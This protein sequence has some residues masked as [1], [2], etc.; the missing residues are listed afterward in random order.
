MNLKR[1]PSLS[2]NETM[3]KRRRTAGAENCKKGGNVY[4]VISLSLFH[5]RASVRKKEKGFR[6]GGEKRESDTSTLPTQSKLNYSSF[7]IR[8]RERSSWKNCLQSKDHAHLARNGNCGNK[9]AQKCSVE[10]KHES[11]FVFQS[12]HPLSYF[13]PGLVWIDEHSAAKLRIPAE[14]FANKAAER[15]PEI[16]YRLRGGG[17][18][19]PQGFLI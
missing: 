12:R 2:T 10:G 1:V 14:S 11:G 8:D 9:K 4:V 3:S 5:C 19:R 15:V 13:P 7:H 6:R 16:G 18:G 17:G